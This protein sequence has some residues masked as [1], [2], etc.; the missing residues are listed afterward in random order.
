MTDNFRISYSS[1]GTFASC[2]RKFE[3]QK[4]YTQPAREFLSV[5]AGAGS[6]LHAGYQEFLVSRDLDK[7]LWVMSLEYPHIHCWDEDDDRSWEACMATL[8]TMCEYDLHSDWTVADIVN[9]EGKVVPA[10][11]VPFEIKLDGLYL[12]DGRGVSIVGFIDT[13][14]HRYNGTEYGTIDIKTH[15]SRQKDRTSK[16]IN[17]TQQVPYGIVLQHVLQEDVNNFKVHYM[18]VFVDILDSYV[19]EYTFTKNSTAVTEWLIHV[20]DEVQRII[21]YAE[22]DLFPRATHG[23]EFYMKPCKFLDMCASRNRETIQKLLLLD[24]DP[25]EE[26]PWNPWVVCNISES[27]IKEIMHV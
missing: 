24:G 3:L 27:Q 6:A 2:P 18:D 25:P 5:A 12:P 8:I 20:V 19:S 17:D 21:K 11:E 1:M 22:R 13:L 10:I 9:H 7:A 16:F 26:K 14:M 4:L 23:C 15:R